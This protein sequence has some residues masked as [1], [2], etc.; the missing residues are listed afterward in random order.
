MKKWL[1]SVFELIAKENEFE[2]VIHENSDKALICEFVTFTSIHKKNKVIRKYLVFGIDRSNQS[3]A[4]EKVKN[5]CFEHCHQIGVIQKTFI[6]DFEVDEELDSL[7]T[8][9]RVYKLQI[10]G[11]NFE[12]PNTKLVSNFT[13]A[14]L[15]GI[16]KSEL[17]QSINSVSE[18]KIHSIEIKDVKGAQELLFLDI[19]RMIILQFNI[20]NN[21]IINSRIIGRDLDGFYRFKEET[22]VVIQRRFEGGLYRFYLPDMEHFWQLA[23][24]VIDLS[25]VFKALILNKKKLSTEIKIIKDSIQSILNYTFSWIDA[26]STS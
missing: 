11:E 23:T 25:V 3:W 18:E 4:V 17:Y 19:I 5:F 8:I 9:H 12:S 10:L 2:L 1:L 22:G 16:V 14:I 21:I 15:G 24:H 6:S 7:L 26:K 20:L 13:Y